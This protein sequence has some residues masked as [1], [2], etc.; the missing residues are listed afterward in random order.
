LPELNEGQEVRSNELRDY[1][2]KDTNTSEEQIIINS[3]DGSTNYHELAAMLRDLNHW[4]GLRGPLV[5]DL[6]GT[7]HVFKASYNRKDIVE[8]FTATL[9]SRLELRRKDQLDLG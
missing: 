6:G 4:G 2:E 5:R 9:L 8:T 3:I 7:I 1:S